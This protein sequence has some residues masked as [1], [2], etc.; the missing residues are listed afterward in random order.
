MRFNQVTSHAELSAK[1]VHANFGPPPTSPE[2]VVVTALAF[3]A[4]LA[5][6]AAWVERIATNEVK[7]GQ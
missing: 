6:V 5:L 7:L 1:Q 3:Y 4:V 2:A